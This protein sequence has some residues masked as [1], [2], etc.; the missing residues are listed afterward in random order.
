MTREAQAD[1]YSRS[2][3]TLPRWQTAPLRPPAGVHRG[4]RRQWLPQR[5]GPDRQS[6]VSHQGRSPLQTQSATAA[7]VLPPLPTTAPRAHCRPRWQRHG[8]RP[9]D[10][11]FC[12]SA[13]WGGYPTRKCDRAQPMEEAYARCR[14]WQRQQARRFDRA[15]GRQQARRRGFLRHRARRPR[16]SRAVRVPCGE[17][18]AT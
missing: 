2:Q 7:A 8:P 17:A 6:S 5:P 16:L 18:G 3:P 11:M 10:G 4:I 15:A 13:W 9:H 12:R 1:V 14:P